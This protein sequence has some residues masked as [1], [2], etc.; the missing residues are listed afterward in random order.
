MAGFSA[1]T[2]CSRN[3]ENIREEAVRWRGAG[4]IQKPPWWEIVSNKP[5]SSSSCKL[6]PHPTVGPLQ[7]S[8][9][10]PPIHWMDVP[11]VGALC[12]HWGS[13]RCFAKWICQRKLLLVWGKE[14]SVASYDQD[15]QNKEDWLVSLLKYMSELGLCDSQSYCSVSPVVGSLVS[16]PRSLKGSFTLQCSSD[17]TQF[18]SSH[19]LCRLKARSD[20]RY[21]SSKPSHRLQGSQSTHTANLGVPSTHPP[22]LLICYNDSQNSGW[23]QFYYRRYKSGLAK[24]R[25]AWDE[26]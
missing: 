11:W 13:Q 24:W 8:H 18:W 22:G 26:V 23:L 6:I 16:L 14:C 7:L 17:T 5:P 2:V 20:A 10:L 19:T 15:E 4:L 3:C 25:D 12:V 9:C 1:P 21:P